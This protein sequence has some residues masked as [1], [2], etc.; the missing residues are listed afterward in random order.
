[1]SF[2]SLSSAED[3]DNVFSTN[4]ERIPLGRR[5]KLETRAQRLGNTAKRTNGLN[6]PVQPHVNAGKKI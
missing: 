4:D 1:M 6:A 2:S 3:D 5:N